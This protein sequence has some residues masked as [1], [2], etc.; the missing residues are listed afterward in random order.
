[1]IEELSSAPLRYVVIDPL[2][3]EVVEPNAS[4][5]SSGVTLLDDWLHARF[6]PV[7]RAGK[8]TV[9]APNQASGR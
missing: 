2:K 9:L 8:L 1:M 7:F 5:E 3:E 6:H 4:A